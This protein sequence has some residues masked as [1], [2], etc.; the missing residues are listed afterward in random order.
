MPLSRV[1]R[2][3]R[4]RVARPSATR[5]NGIDAFGTLHVPGLEDVRVRLIEYEANRFAAFAS[6]A[7]DEPRLIEVESYTVSGRTLSGTTETG[8]E[9]KFR[10]AGC[11]CETPQDLRGSRAALLAAVP[12]LVDGD[13]Q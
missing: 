9:F 7:R 2:Q 6:G 10:K 8:L 4:Q 3:Q 13:E 11:G 5:F 12:G 1:A